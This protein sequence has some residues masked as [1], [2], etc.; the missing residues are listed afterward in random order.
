MRGIEYTWDERK[1]VS[2]LAKHKIEFTD[3][4]SFN[5]GIAT[6]VPDKEYGDRMIATSYIDSR[7]CVAVYTEQES[8]KIHVISLRKATKEEIRKYA[9]T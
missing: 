6:I 4:N 8:G 9:E 1:R 7:V 2:N 3:M 5:W